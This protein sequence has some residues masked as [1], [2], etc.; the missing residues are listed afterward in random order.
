MDD[1]EFQT[2]LGDAARMKEK[3]QKKEKKAKK[4]KR[5]EKKL[6]K[7][8]EKARL[9]HHDINR[10]TKKTLRAR[11]CPLEFRKIRI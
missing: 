3:K 4:E 6:A 8:V 7:L 9:C 11:F 2:V 5:K 10:N 1:P